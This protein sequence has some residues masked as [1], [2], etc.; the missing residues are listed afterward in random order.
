[1]T[2]DHIRDEIAIRVSFSRSK[3]E[4]G[5]LPRGRRNHLKE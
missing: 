4:A 1:M 5:Q 2:L 3:K